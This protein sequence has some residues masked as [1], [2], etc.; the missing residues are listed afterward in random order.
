MNTE[1]LSECT[2]DA[3]GTRIEWGGIQTDA[4]HHYYHRYGVCRCEEREWYT[5]EYGLQPQR[6]THPRY[7]R[8]EEERHE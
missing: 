1:S 2:C 7:H 6:W 4:G 5:Q 3:C 8:R